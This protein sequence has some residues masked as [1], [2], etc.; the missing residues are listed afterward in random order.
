[1]EISPTSEWK[2]V[3]L[4]SFGAKAERPAVAVAAP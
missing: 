4:A 3:H 1:M 2:P